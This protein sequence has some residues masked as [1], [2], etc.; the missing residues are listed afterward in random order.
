M[1]IEGMGA[2]LAGASWDAQA[3][4]GAGGE[5]NLGRAVDLGQSPSDP[6][7]LALLPETYAAN[8]DV[9]PLSITDGVLTLACTD[10]DDLRL[11]REVQVV[12]RHAIQA[13]VAPAYEIQEAIRERYRVLAGV[14]EH[15]RAATERL[16]VGEAGGAA[17][18][19]EAVS[20]D[21]PVVQIVDLLIAQG[22]RDRA[23][24]I[25]IEPQ[26][27]HLRIRF[28]ID[29]MLKDALSL[30]TALGPALASR[31]KV[32]ANMDIVDRHRAQDGQVRTR[33]EHRDV[34]I[35][36]STASTIWGEKLVLRLLDQQRTVLKLDQLGLSGL[37]YQRLA[38]LLRSPFG[39]VV[40]AGPTG[41]GKTT[42]LYA[43][44]TE[45]D[46]V[47]QNIVTI[48]DPVEYTFENINQIQVR[49]VANMNFANGLRAVLR[50][51]PDVI[52]IGEIRDLETAEIAVQSSL[53]GH[54][55]LSS[56][57]ATDAAGVIQRF[58]EMGIEG[59]LVSSSLIGVVA[60][61][62]VRRVCSYCSEPYR[63][64]PAELQLW[65]DHSYGDHAFRR[66]RGCQHCA[67]TGYRGRIGVFEVLPLTDSI[68]RLIVD[69]ASTQSIR[70]AAI[71]EGMLPLRAAGVEK[72]AEDVTTLSEVIRCV[73]IN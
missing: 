7:A 18:A 59:Y 8:H 24:D 52:L 57:H 22:L 58:M 66:G 23:S 29:G 61:R 63:P 64:E 15:V 20:P 26:Q 31:L 25:H 71:H 1:P 4:P 67:G 56:V 2:D 69:K 35:R 70:E 40:V 34:D 55:V 73:W 19:L 49:R 36:V 21:S 33:V 65:R 39:M 42:S 46:P 30:P 37:A 43:A 62:L 3:I 38:T 48:E 14:D 53:T 16:G 45:L 11:L 72:V 50:Q 9:L 47:V 5:G 51:D 12:S 6:Q 27:N 54:L 68:K 13:L 32:M 41:S 10:P 17:A 44:I 28:R 60:Q